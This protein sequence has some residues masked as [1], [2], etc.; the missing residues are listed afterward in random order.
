MDTQNNKTI[1]RVLVE[2]V[3]NGDL[4]RLNDYLTDDYIDH[5]D[6][7]DRDGLR[8]TLTDFRAS[9]PDLTFRIEDL[10]AE[11]DRVAA[12]TTVVGHRPDEEKTI[13]AISVYRLL[14]GR[15]VERWGYSDSFF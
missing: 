10:I 11:G 9:Y 3:F 1:V 8:K 2:D 5:S 13:H 15:V 14:D 6:W 12:R 4:H 7:G